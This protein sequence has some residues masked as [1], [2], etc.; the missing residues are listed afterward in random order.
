M[1]VLAIYKD[2]HGNP[3]HDKRHIMVLGNKDPNQWTR[4]DCLAPMT[5]QSAVRLVASLTIEHNKFAQQGDCKNAFC[6]PFLPDDEVVIY[7][8]LKDAHSPN[9]IHYGDSAKHFMEYVYHP[10][11]GMIC[12]DL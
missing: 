1:C 4:G 6:N 2:E 11:I 3:V 5:T 7:P 8:P 9:L 10:S 12:S